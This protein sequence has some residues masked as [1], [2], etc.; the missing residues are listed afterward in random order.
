MSLTVAAAGAAEPQAAAPWAAGEDRSNFQPVTGWGSN[1]FG[2]CKATEGLTFTDHTFAANWHNLKAEGKPRIAYHFFH[3]S[4]SAIDQAH[5][6]FSTVAAQGLEPGDALAA[7]IEITVGVDGSW[8][9]TPSGAARSNMLYLVSEAAPPVHAGVVGSS[10]RLFLDT[11]RSL[12]GPHSPV[13]VYTDLSVGST[14]GACTAYPLWIAFP[15]ASPPANVRPWSDW[16]FWQNAFGGGQGGGDRD[17]FHGSKNDLLLWH[18][19]HAG[20]PPQ[21]RPKPGHTYITGDDIMFQ[22]PN[23]GVAIAPLIPAAVPQPDGSFAQPTVLRLGAT[24]PRSVE[25]ML[26]NDGAWRPAQIDYGR[27][28]NTYPIEGAAS[29]KIRTQDT[30]TG[31]GVITGDFA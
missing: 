4:L 23:G 3:P 7:D 1:D 20:P 30:D 12:A 29:V 21:P 27:T 26:N 14:L 25:Y 28:P 13:L 17:K 18:G 9:I 19:S 6:F 24:Q 8:Y 31:T 10:S 15:A 22:V 11:V 16:L 5:F 2:A